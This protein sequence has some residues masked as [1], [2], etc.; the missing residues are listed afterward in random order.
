MSDESA[1]AEAMSV[2]AT[3]TATATVV[4]EAPRR[5]RVAPFI[6]LAVAL[7]LGALFWVLAASKA[8]TADEQGVVESPLLGR[9]APAVRA[10][11]ADGD[12]FDLTRRKGSWVVV[13]FFNSTCVPCKA[14]H[15]QLM[16]FVAQQG[17]LGGLG[18]ELYAISGYPDTPETIAE[19]FTERGGDWPVVMDPDGT[20]SVAFG[21]AQW[22]ETFVIDPDGMVVLRWAGPIDA[23]TLAELVQQ[24]RIAYGA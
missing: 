10:I 13:N 3:A 11:T 17:T 12:A 23:F 19:F 16:M 2:T 18:A 6:A 15:E 7:V 5:R 9:P 20:A 22:P 14:E 4:I 8:D 21:V 1:P 24:Q